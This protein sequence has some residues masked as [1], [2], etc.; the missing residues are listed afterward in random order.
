MEV[1]KIKEVSEYLHCS[2]SCIRTLVKTNQIPHFRL[3]NRLYFNKNIIDDWI[4]NNPTN[5]LVQHNKQ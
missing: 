5:N 3:G 1:F 2:I 4:Y